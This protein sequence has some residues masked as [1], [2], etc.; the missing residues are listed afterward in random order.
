MCSTPPPITTSWT[1]EATSAAP[2]LTACWAE[3]HWRSTVVAGVSTGRPACSQ[4][5]R[6]DV[7]ALLA[8]LLDAA[9][10][11]VLDGVG[12]DA[13]ALDHRGE[14]LAEQLVRVRVLVVALLGVTAPDRRARGL[15]DDDFPASYRSA[16]LRLRCRAG[17]FRVRAGA[18]R[19]ESLRAPA[20]AM[21]L[22][23]THESTGGKR[24]R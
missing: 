12:G 16:S 8:D 6:P 18:R 13:G 1:P 17:R 5:L 10:D 24:P 7:E 20:A 3:P 15:D 22:R 14:R 2:K 21:L 19:G 9:G 11:H 23:L 4:A